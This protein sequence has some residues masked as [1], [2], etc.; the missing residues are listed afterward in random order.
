MGQDGTAVLRR[1]D[2]IFDPVATEREVASICAQVRR[3]CLLYKFL[4][5]LGSYQ[6]LLHAVDR[7]MSVVFF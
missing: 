3:L 5:L 7:A 6:H 1:V 4:L 2:P